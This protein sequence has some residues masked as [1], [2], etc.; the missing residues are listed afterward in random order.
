MSTLSNTQFAPSN[1][2]WWQNGAGTGT[3]V[4]VKDNDTRSLYFAF[5]TGHTAYQLQYRTRR[6][7]TPAECDAA[8][9]GSYDVWDDW[10]DWQGSDLTQDTALFRRADVSTEDYTVIVDISGYNFAGKF[11]K[12]VDGD[13]YQVDLRVRT[14]NTTRAWHSKWANAIL[15]VIFEPEPTL[16]VSVNAN[17]TLACTFTDNWQREAWINDMRVLDYYSADYSSSVMS[18]IYGR[19]WLDNKTDTFS[20]LRARDFKARVGRTYAVRYCYQTADGLNSLQYREVKFTRTGGTPSGITEPIVSVSTT[21]TNSI[22]VDITG[23]YNAIYGTVS[24]TTAQ[25]VEVID[26]LDFGSSQSTTYLYPPLGR[27]MTFTV[28]G[29]KSGQYVTTTTTYTISAKDKAHNGAWWNYEGECVRAYLKES[30]DAVDDD[31]T[32][33]ADTIKTIGRQRPISRYGTGGTRSLKASC[34]FLRGEL[35][36]QNPEYA[37]SWALERLHAKHSWVFRT[38]TGRWHRVMVTSISITD[39]SSEQYISAD[40]TMEEVE[41]LGEE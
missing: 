23:S 32:L 27:E 26:A 30:G 1:L 24:F 12:M 4:S 29:T 6:R 15:N 5:D 38:S 13:K 22:Q 35:E 2:Q 31:Y 36:S 28:S 40:V 18:Y 7:W 41:G 39:N 19:Y 25:G 20:T 16:Q 11:G 10:S 34:V 21:S 14:F 9:E 8:G 33:E 17:G 3:T 37:E